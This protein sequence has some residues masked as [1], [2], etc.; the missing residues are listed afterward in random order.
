MSRL[1]W[2]IMIA[3]VLS[4]S[5][6]GTLELSMEVLK[7]LRG[8]DWSK[9]TLHD[10]ISDDDYTAARSLDGSLVLL[11]YLGYVEG[12]DAE[13]RTSTDANFT[14]GQFLQDLFAKLE[15]D[16]VLPPMLAY[17]ITAVE[18]DA[19]VVNNELL[20]T[21]YSQLRNFLLLSNV[22]KDEAGDRVRFHVD[23]AY[24][25]LF[26]KYAEARDPPK[27]LEEFKQELAERERR[28]REAEEFVVA[29]ER[30]QRSGHPDCDQIRRVSVENVEAGYDVASYASDESA[31][32]DKFIEVKSYLGAKRIYWSRNE[33]KVA[34]KLGT[35]YF[36]YLV[37]SDR[38]QEPGYE[39]EIIANPHQTL[40]NAEKTCE[41]WRY[42]IP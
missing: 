35:A 34:E 32:L 1:S 24:T 2:M 30:R 10:Y 18:G 9:Q 13:L 33:Q 38:I 37:D 7:A 15:E 29:Y 17:P 8:K 12:D 16:R 23:E 5:D 39:P 4:A 22:M 20:S 25:Y 14:A 40:Q 26:K 6:I 11:R 28:G 21:D 19:V 36:L 31:E 42:D 41:T 3:N 27:T